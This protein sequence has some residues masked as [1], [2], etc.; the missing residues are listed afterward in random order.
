VQRLG[1]SPAA[2]NAFS[3]KQTKKITTLFEISKVR[4]QKKTVNACVPQIPCSDALSI[5][6]N[7][8]RTLVIVNNYYYSLLL[9]GRVVKC[10]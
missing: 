4:V 5:V 8:C 7:Q 10:K 3:I 6:C 9:N 2:G 1:E